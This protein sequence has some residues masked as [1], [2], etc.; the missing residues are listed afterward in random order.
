MNYKKSE[1]KA[2]AQAQFRGI[3]A[4]I[5]TPFTADF[6][7]DEAG[8]RRNMRHLTD[9]LAI[10]GVFCTGVMGEFWALT[11]EERMRVVEVVVEEARGK[12]GVIAQTGSHSAHETIELTRH[13]EEVGADF[14]IMMGPYYPHTDEAMIL[15]WFTFVASRVNLGIW[16]FDTGFSGRPA[17]SPETTAKIAEIDNVCGAKISRPLDHY[18]AV[19]KLCGKRIVMSS[20][21]EADFLMMMRDHGQRVHQSSASPYLIQTAE[22][23]EMRAYAGRALAGRFDEAATISAGLDALREVSHRWIMGRWRE[24]GV[25]PIAAIKEWSA[26]L[27]LAAGPVRTPL[28]QMSADDRAAMRR[29]LEATGILNGALVAEVA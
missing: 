2:A 29:D 23:Q 6:A 8:L 25:I 5:T 15:D 13:A 1:A 10:D 22:R 3:W 14:A 20:P 16:L 7:L 4:A 9:T 12:C 18:V 11:K 28:L 19:R 17:I 26:M 21:N 27:G 24:T